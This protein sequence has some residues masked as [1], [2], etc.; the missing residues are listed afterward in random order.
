L[1]Q[2]V[3]K[4]D[5]FTAALTVLADEGHGAL[6]IG[7]LCRGLGVTAGSFYNY[8]GSLDGFVSE[9]LGYWEQEKTQ[10]IFAAAS[11]LADPVDRVKLVKSLAVELPHEAETAIRAW[12]HINPVVA[13]TQQRVDQERQ[14][15][16]REVLAGVIPIE[17]EADELA[18]MGLSLL[19]GIQQWRSPV[20]P[21]ELGRVLDEFEMLVM[22][23][24]R[25]L[26]VH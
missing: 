13:E 16:L 25:A 20:D 9:L 2:L 1:R 10:R 26:A 3:T 18:I 8:F 7:S 23:R 4:I 6:K 22:N 15:A 21:V 24:A 19:V 11:A 12:A 5:Y 17:R 14:T